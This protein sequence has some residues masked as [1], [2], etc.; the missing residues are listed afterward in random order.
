VGKVKNK[1]KQFEGLSPEELLSFVRRNISIPKYMD[2]FLYTHK[3]SLSKLV[4]T[5]IIDRMKEEEGKTVEKQV[6]EETQR[7]KI[8][9]QFAQEK[10]KNPNFEWDLERAKRLLS[11][12]FTHYDKGDIEEAERQKQILLQEFSDLYLDVVRFERWR[13]DHEKDY[14]LMKERYANPVERLVRIKTDYL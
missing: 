11:M 13:H 14:M 3:I 10:R 4:Q 1:V 6:K 9:Q 8:Q 2:V 5:A 7:K 12:Y